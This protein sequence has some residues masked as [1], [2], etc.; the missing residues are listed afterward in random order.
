MTHGPATGVPIAHPTDHPCN[1]GRSMLL[2]SVS[3]WHLSPVD[4]NARRSGRLATRE[5][6][7]DD[8]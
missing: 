2:Q 5:P 1:T 7:E 6:R 3:V 8:R 4:A